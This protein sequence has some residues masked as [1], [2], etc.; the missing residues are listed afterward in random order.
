M[1][2]NSETKCHHSSRMSDYFCTILF[3]KAKQIPHLN[4]RLEVEPTLHLIVV[5]QMIR[6]Y[7]ALTHSPYVLFCSWWIR[8]HRVWVV[9][10]LIPSKGYWYFLSRMKW[11]GTCLLCIID[12]NGKSFTQSISGLNLFSG[13][14]GYWLQGIESSSVYISILFGLS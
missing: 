11:V 6:S 2:R 10:I 7:F 13:R 3:R 1:T 9:V 8:I 4:Q 14:Y 12:W 5:G